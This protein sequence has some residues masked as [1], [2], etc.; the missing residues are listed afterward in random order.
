MGVAATPNAV[1][2]LLES[3]LTTL[4]F[5]LTLITLHIL[6]PTAHIA[7]FTSSFPADPP[8][9]ETPQSHADKVS[10]SEPETPLIND[11]LIQRR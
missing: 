3:R 8:G 9:T 10:L 6:S 5:S 4:K 2:N 11:S 1:I 7:H